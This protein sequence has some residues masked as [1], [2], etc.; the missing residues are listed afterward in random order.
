V[1]N[2]TTPAALQLGKE[3]LVFTE[4]EAGWASVTVWTQWQTGNIPTPTGNQTP[5]IQ[6][7][8]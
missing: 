3:P 8:A 7:V 6:P 2:F 5:V 4:W 1:V